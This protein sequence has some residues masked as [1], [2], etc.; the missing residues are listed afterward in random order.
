MW[1]LFCLAEPSVV[2]HCELCWTSGCESWWVM[3]NQWLRIMEWD[4]EPVVVKH[5]VLCCASGSETLCA[6]LCQCVGI[7]VCYAVQVVLN[8]MCYAGQSK[9]FA[10]FINEPN[11][12]VSD[13]CLTPSQQCVTYIMRRTSYFLMN[14][15]RGP[16]CTRPVWLFVL[17]HWNRSL[18][19]HM[20][21]HG[22]HYPD[23]EPTS[24]CSFSLILCV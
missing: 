11:E 15:W 12:W 23:S 3:L 21:P 2:I 16:L 17:D 4:T 19:I 1:I 14:W 9:L 18:R 10:L 7:M 20:S 22:S 24:I 13:C 6:M 5:C 8:H